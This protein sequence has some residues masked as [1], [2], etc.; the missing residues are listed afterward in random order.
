MK[1]PHRRTFLQLTAGVATFPA[2]SRIPGAQTYPSRRVR[3][4]VG[5][6]PGSTAGLPEILMVGDSALT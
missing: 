2:I 6:V 4:I 5:F 3:I 1:L